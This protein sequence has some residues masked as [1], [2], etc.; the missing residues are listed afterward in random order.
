[1][2]FINQHVVGS[3]GKASNKEA[4]GGPWRG[5]KVC[6]QCRQ[7]VP[8]SDYPLALSGRCWYSVELRVE[9]MR[10]SRDLQAS[11]THRR[12]GGAFEGEHCSQSCST[13]CSSIKAALLPKSY[14]GK[15]NEG[16]EDLL[17]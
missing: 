4:A 12:L 3:R 14:Q 11:K 7:T 9:N 5:A 1:M 13:G 6:Q 15:S 8:S 10:K 2:T 17:S 16:R